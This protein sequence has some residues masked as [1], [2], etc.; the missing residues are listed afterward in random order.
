M[1]RFEGKVVLVTGTSRNTGV[2][3]A[4]LFIREGAFVFVCSS[5]PESTAKGARQLHDMG[6]TNFIEAPAD[7]SDPESVDKLFQ[8]IQEKTGRLDILVNNACNQGIGPAFEDIPY[9]FFKKVILTN[10]GGTFYVS[11]QAARMMLRQESR[12][13]IVNLGSNVSMRAIR[14]RT[15]YVSSK[16]GIDALTRSMAVDL[17]PKGIRVNEVAPGYIYTDRWDALDEGT[18]TRRRMNCPLRQEATA[19]DI[20]QT[21]AFLASDASR[22]ICGERIV[23]DAGCSA[24]HMPE[25]VDR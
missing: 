15:A 22:N 9:D 25:D 17:G 10:L 4:A 1:K 24:Q 11:Q 21:V 6:L 2:G 13:V 3:I 7:I 14:N 12:G 5:S 20:A 19:D 16:G 8:F 18:R 23:V